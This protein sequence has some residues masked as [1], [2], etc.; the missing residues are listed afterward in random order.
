VSL[1]PAVT[2]TMD[3]ETFVRLACGRVRPQVVADHVKVEGDEALAERILA[4]FAVTP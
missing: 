2:L 3:W 1:G 4:H